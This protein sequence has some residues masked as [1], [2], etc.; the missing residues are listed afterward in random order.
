MTA[1]DLLVVAIPGLPLAA[2]LL[3]TADR[4]LGGRLLSARLLARVAVWS[5]GLSAA[6]ATAAAVIAFAWPRPRVVELGTWLQTA[7]LQVDV[8]FLLDPL[9]A[10]MAVTVAGVSWLV[11]RF[12]VNYLHNEVGSGRYFTV[13]PLFVG[14]MLLLVLAENYLMLFVAWEVVGACSYLLIAFYRDRNSAAEAGTRAFLL[15]R[16]GDA[17][18]LAGLFVLAVEGRGLAYSEVLTSPL[19]AGTA[20]AVGFC[21]LIGAMGKSA[22]F[23]LGG[24]LAR[25]ME[26]PT[27]SSALIHGAT[28]VTA[29]VYLVVRSAPVYEQA[30]VA[31]VAVGVIGAATVLFGQLAGLTQTDVKGMLAAS[32]NAHLGFMLLLSGLGLYPIAVF[33]LVAHAF[34]KTNLFLTAPSILHHLHGGPDPT[35]VARPVDTARAPSVLVG[36]GAVLLLGLPLAAGWLS[37]PSQ[38]ARGAIALGGLAVVAAFGLWFSTHRMVRAAFHDGGGSG[39]RTAIAIAVGVAVVAAGVVLGIQPGGIGGSWFADLLAPAVS[40]TTAPLDAPPAATALLIAALVF[41]VISGIAVPRFFDRFRPEQPAGT[42]SAFARR[43]YFAASNRMWLD[44]FADRATGAAVRVGAAVDRFDRVVLDPLTGALLPSHT[45]PKEATWEARL[46]AATETAGA[47]AA[48]EFEWLRGH[49]VPVPVKGRTRGTPKERISAATARIERG[50]TSQ[51]GGLYGA[52]TSAIAAVSD[53]AERLVFQ[54]GIESV[55]ERFTGALAALSEAI[56]RRVFELGPDRIGRFGHSIRRSLLRI[57]VLLGR[58]VVAAL[59]AF[60]TIAALWAGR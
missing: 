47:H 57:E 20:T 30:P 4:V 43:L 37:L 39:R 27:P 2:A 36:A 25:A 54:R 12:S 5:V 16:I 15:N 56:E 52:L 55:L 23:P 44:D 34:Y 14:A 59:M 29:G 50:I 1:S 17:G 11:A 21:F 40:A 53:R 35:E 60:A 45:A 31:L 10:T 24:W 48:G 9:S 33:H 8:G 58:P 28:M 18:L 26:G 42:G 49:G 46:G 19:S 6:A 3:A 51:G 38:W 22:Q 32:T 41:L 13:L 7:S